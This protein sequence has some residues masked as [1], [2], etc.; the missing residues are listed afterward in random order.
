MQL[1]CMQ[2]REEKQQLEVQ[3]VYTNANQTHIDCVDAVYCGLNKMQTATNNKAQW[4]RGICISLTFVW[5]DKVFLIRKRVHFIQ[6]IISHVE[7]VI[8]LG[9]QCCCLIDIS[10]CDSIK[11]IVFFMTFFFLQLEYRLQNNL[12]RKKS[13]MSNHLFGNRFGAPRC[14]Y[15]IAF[16][17]VE[18]R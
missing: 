3:S 11:L 1:N 17:V 10:P 13:K 18:S 7:K 12:R 2:L 14:H 4:F 9:F 16:V 6:I 15:S 8:D 5:F